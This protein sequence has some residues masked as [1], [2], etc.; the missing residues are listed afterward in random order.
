MSSLFDVNFLHNTIGS[1]GRPVEACPT[2]ILPSCSLHKRVVYNGVVRTFNTNK[3]AFRNFKSFVSSPHPA[4]I[5]LFRSMVPLARAT[6]RLPNSTMLPL[7]ETLVVLICQSLSVIGVC[8]KKL[9]LSKS[10]PFLFFF[11]R[12]T[13]ETEYCPRDQWHRCI[14]FY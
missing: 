8:L 6:L 5:F 4:A 3:V 13:D 14:R 1:G 10:V 2:P 11:G 12:L 7:S 9:C